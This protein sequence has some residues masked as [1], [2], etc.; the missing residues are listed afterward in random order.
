VTE[1]TIDLYGD[2]G[3]ARD[4][5]P[6][7]IKA[8]YRRLAMQH[9]PD[10]GGDDDA[11]KKVQN[12]YDVLSDLE[13]RA[14][15]DATGMM[16]GRKADEEEMLRREAIKIFSEAINSVGDKPQRFDLVGVMVDV[17]N[18]KQNE[19]T[20][21]IVRTRKQIETLEKCR[22]RMKRKDG[23]SGPNALGDFIESNLLAAKD[24]L[25]RLEEMLA[26]GVKLLEYIQTYTF[27][28]EP[29]PESTI[30]RSFMVWPTSTS[31]G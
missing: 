23:S 25:R 30:K 28:P 4:A 1:E 31:T 12:A 3:V 18:Q 14:E 29:E 27:E 24:E 19:F 5:T 21:L 20:R 17:V 22:P 10:R 2:L 9:H 8:A 26:F 16:P 15:Y 11:F 13:K 7:E 6:E